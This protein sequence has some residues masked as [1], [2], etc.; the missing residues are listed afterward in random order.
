MH[1]N[2]DMFSTGKT[3]DL[4]AIV[5]SQIGKD[6]ICN[7]PL[8]F[9]Q[10]LQDVRYTAKHALMFVL[11]YVVLGSCALIGE[12]TEVRPESPG[13]PYASICPGYDE[14]S[15]CFPHHFLGV[16]IGVHEDADTA[17][18]LAELFALGELTQSVSVIVVNAVIDVVGDGYEEFS[19][20]SRLVSDI[21][22]RNVAYPELNRHKDAH[23]RYCVTV[24]AVKE[25]QAYFDGYVRLIPDEDRIEVADVLKKVMDE[26]EEKW[27]DY[28]D[29]VLRKS[30]TNRDF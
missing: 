15:A 6:V 16:G 9:A 10:R 26:L 12:N 21:R 5:D 1:R 20:I 24:L 27:R 17:R 14:V 30:L 11:L 3:V 7:L 23:G 2:S 13:P 29:P 18:T 28:A 19:S 25:K 4:L 8:P 22:I